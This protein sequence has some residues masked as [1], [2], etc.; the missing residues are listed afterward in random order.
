MWG[1]LPAL[2]NLMR[3]FM[4]RSIA[5]EGSYSLTNTGMSSKG[6]A[7]VIWMPLS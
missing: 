4:N 3:R 7:I 6:D 5:I 1:K 2:H